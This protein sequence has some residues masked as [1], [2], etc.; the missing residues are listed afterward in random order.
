MSCTYIH[1]RTRYRELAELM[2]GCEILKYSYLLTQASKKYDQTVIGK[3]RPRRIQPKGGNIYLT[4]TVDSGLVRICKHTF[5]HS[6]QMEHVICTKN[7]LTE[8]DR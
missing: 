7:T 8:Q 6:H 3:L 1:I 5:T 2:S 4:V